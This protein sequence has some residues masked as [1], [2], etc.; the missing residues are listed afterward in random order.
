M[1][2]SMDKKYSNVPNL[3]FPGF[4]DKWSHS[5]LSECCLINPKNTYDI[6]NSFLY[7]DLESV[8]SGMLCKENFIDKSEAPSR[9]QRCLLDED[10]LYSCVRPYQHNNFIFKGNNKVVASTGFAILRNQVSS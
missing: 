6:P 1:A 9:A 7:I 2:D 8:K 4:S 10:I 5:K 3:R